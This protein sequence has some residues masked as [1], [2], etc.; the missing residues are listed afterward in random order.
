MKYTRK[1]TSLW[2]VGDTDSMWGY[3]MMG[4]ETVRR[5]QVAC[6]P[7]VLFLSAE[8]DICATGNGDTMKQG[9]DGHELLQHYY[10]QQKVS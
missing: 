3:T 6:S 2:A 10:T 4:C 8:Y 5:R 7:V 1:Y 9:T